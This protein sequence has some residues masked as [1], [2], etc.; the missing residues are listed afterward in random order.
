[1]TKLNPRAESEG[2]SQHHVYVCARLSLLTGATWILSLVAEGL[3]V[4]WLQFFSIMTNGGQG[5]LLFLSYVMTRRVAAMLAVKLGCKVKSS[6]SHT[7][8][9]TART[10]FSPDVTSDKD[11]GNKDLNKI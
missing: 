10:A 6:S 3:G 8:S 9:T 5:L 11:V 1:M 7:T 4:D 2:D